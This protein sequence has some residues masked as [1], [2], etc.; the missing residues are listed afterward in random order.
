VDINQFY[1]AKAACAQD[2]QRGFL[3]KTKRFLLFG[4]PVVLLVLGIVLAGCD[5]D[6]DEPYDG[7]KSF[8]VTGINKTAIKANARV[9]IISHDDDLPAN[10]QVAEGTLVANVKEKKL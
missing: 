10:G 7:P 1:A 4:L 2:A 6:S 9:Q 8:K 3:M 5:D